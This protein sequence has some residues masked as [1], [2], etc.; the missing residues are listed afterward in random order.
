MQNLGTVGAA[1]AA[2]LLIG[3]MLSTPLLMPLGWKIVGLL[4][5]GLLTFGVFYYCGQRYSPAAGWLASS[6]VFTFCLLLLG[7]I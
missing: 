6:V 2:V 4:L 7:T 3:N 1:A 5:A